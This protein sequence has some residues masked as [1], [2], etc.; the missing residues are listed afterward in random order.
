MA[1]VD[2]PVELVRAAA[3]GDAGAMRRLLEAVAPA[4]HRVARTVLGPANPDVQDAV[5]ESLVALAEAVDR[6]RGESGVLHFACR[7][8]LHVSVSARRKAEVRRTAAEAFG[9][10]ARGVPAPP[11]RSDEEVAA[12]R[13]RDVVRGLLDRLPEAQAEALALRFVLGCTL[14]EIAE[15]TGAPENTVRSRLR[16]AKEALQRRIAED[17]AVADLQKDVG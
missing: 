12:G 9:E 3:R 17:S 6:F 4:V 7:I 13:R 2:P 14:R 11:A 15:A 16:L 1:P 8:A 10:E 5:Q